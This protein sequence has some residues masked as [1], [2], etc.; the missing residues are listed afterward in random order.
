MSLTSIIIAVVGSLLE[1]NHHQSSS[2]T[3]CPGSIPITA[4]SSTRSP[5]DKST[6]AGPF[7]LYRNQRNRQL[8]SPPNRFTT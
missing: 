2:A 8:S 3:S 5:G 7:I 1:L 4:P 6:T